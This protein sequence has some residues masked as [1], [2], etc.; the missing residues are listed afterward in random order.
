MKDFYYGIC[1]AIND[2]TILE[3]RNN[4]CGTVIEFDFFITEAIMNVVFPDI[5]L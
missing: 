4:Q 3:C 2:N 1:C 5:L